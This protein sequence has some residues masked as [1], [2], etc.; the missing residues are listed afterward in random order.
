[1]SG[2]FRGVLHRISS[3]AE[4]RPLAFSIGT[5]GNIYGAGD[6]LAQ[7]G[8]QLYNERSTSGAGACSPEPD[9][10][11]CPSS[12][13]GSATDGSRRMSDIPAGTSSAGGS[14]SSRNSGAA[15]AADIANTSGL[16]LD[17]MQFA[18]VFIYGTV[19]LGPLLGVWYTR[20]LPRLVASSTT[21]RK[22]LVKMVIYDQIIAAPLVDSS[23]L[24]CQTFLQVAQ[25]PD[26]DHH[27]HA[28][29]GRAHEEAVALTRQNF[30]EV[31]KVDVGFWPWVMAANFAFVPMH[32]QTLVVATVSVGWGAFLSC[33]QK[34]E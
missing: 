28:S 19:I 22:K 3:F 6:L 34:S 8:E 18:N 14:S 17:L 2:T 30:L 4:R 10:N 29:Y 23:Y 5:T 25:R 11:V 31:Y 32:L 27:S 20:V 16:R 15:A 24:Y 26:E 9:S 13:S 12:I 21:L 1:M 7:V 33:M